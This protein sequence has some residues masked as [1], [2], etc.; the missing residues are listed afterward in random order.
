MKKVLVAI[1]ILNIGY[2]ILSFETNNNPHLIPLY[3]ETPYTANE[4][5]GTK[6]SEKA[7]LALNKIRLQTKK[8][9]KIV[10][11]YRNPELNEKVGGAKHSMHLQGLA[12]DLKIPVACREEFYS[13]A[14]NAGFKGFGW[15]KST[16]HIDMGEKRWWTYDKQGR[17]LG[18]KKRYKYLCNAPKNFLLD[19][20]IVH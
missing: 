5:G 18:G 8:R 17:H 16:V 13:A 10:S 19:F 14:I 4:C 12:L 9:F 11:G 6:I 7:L 20:N 1:C 15:G 3:W 2:A